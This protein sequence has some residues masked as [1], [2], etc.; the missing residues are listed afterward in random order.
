V[1]HTAGPLPRL[2]SADGS[3]LIGSEVCAG[4][5]RFGVFSGGFIPLPALPAF[6]PMTTGILEGTLAW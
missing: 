2:G 3:V 6:L 5:S 4:H 1:K